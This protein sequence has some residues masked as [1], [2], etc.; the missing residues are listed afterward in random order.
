MS[1]DST[2]KIKQIGNGYDPIEIE[3]G[4]GIA[5]LVD[6]TRYE[7]RSRHNRE[8]VGAPADKTKQIRL[9]PY[10][11]GGIK[12]RDDPDAEIQFI[13]A[14]HKNAVAEVPATVG[15]PRGVDRGQM[16]RVMLESAA[17]LAAN[18]DHGQADELAA[19][20]AGYYSVAADRGGRR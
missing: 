17:A 3:P 1:D 4:T 7:I 15:V 16:Q 14:G 11:S 13:P 6:G 5:L 10:P 19:L 8:G 18:G 9:E 20:A 2:D 12:S